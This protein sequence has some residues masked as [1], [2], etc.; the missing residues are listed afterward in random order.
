MLPCQMGHPTSNSTSLLTEI[1]IKI[2]S[3]RIPPFKI[4]QGNA[5]DTEQL[6]TYDFP[7]VTQG[8]NGQ[9]LYHF[10]DKWQFWSKFTN[11]PH[12][13]CIWLAINRSLV[14]ILASPLSSATLGKLLTHMCLC[15]QAV[16]LDTIQPAVMPCTCEGNRRCGVALATRHRH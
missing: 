5:I 11:F 13:L 6:A 2:W 10:Q 12:P 9:I 16:Y 7:S 1:T 3:P 8:S 15:H 14:R 4:T